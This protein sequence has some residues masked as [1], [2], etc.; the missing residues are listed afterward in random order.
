MLPFWIR[1]CRLVFG[2]TALVAIAYNLRNLD[3][4]RFW[5]FFTNQ[6]NL[7]AG[8]VLVLGALVF[9]RLRNPAW[10]DVVR[11]V[12]LISLLVTGIVYAVLL[13]GVYN[14][15]TTSEHTWA[16]SV[17]H[18]LIPIVMLVDMIIV[19]LGHRTPRWSVVFYLIYPL[20]YLGWALANGSDT[21]WYPYDFVNPNEYSNGYVGVLLTCGALLAVFVLIGLAVIG[22]SRVRRTPGILQVG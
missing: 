14:P 8:I 18:Q 16:S 3:E 13:G 19:P 22:Y 17:M 4:P 7:L 21:G 6:S 15:F 5:S 2:I 1:A 12:A 10:W 11:G 20:T 9:G